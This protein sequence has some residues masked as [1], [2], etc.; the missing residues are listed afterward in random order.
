MLADTFAALRD[1]DR[2]FYLNDPELGEIVR[3]HGTPTL[4]PDHSLAALLRLNGVQP[5]DAAGA[6]DADIWRVGTNG[7]SAEGPH[8][9][10]GRGARDIRQT[11]PATRVSP[12]P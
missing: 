11:R 10:V 8:S 7:R 1:V 5:V 4:R 3:R 9:L 6:P 12:E 2:F